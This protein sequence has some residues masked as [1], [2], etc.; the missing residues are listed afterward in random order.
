MKFFNIN[1][2]SF[3]KKTMAFIYYAF[4][5]LLFILS[6]LSKPNIEVGTYDLVIYK[7]SNILIS[8]SF[9]MLP[10]LSKINGKSVKLK[11]NQRLRSVIFV[12]IFLSF[13]LGG[14]LT[15]YFH[16]ND[17]LSRSTDYNQKE[18]F[19]IEKYIKDLFSKFYNNENTIDTFNDENSNDILKVH[20]ID[21]GQGDSIFLELPNKEKILI[22]AGEKS[23]IENVIRYIENLGY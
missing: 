23:E 13:L 21:V 5:L 15:K 17:Y 3:F 8:I 19:D 2:N 18:F 14:V 11:K 10:L 6:C 1:L 9:L 12:F 16:T 4:C 22:D 7:L 20:F